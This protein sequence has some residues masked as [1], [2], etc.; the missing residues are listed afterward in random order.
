MPENH[1]FKFADDTHLVVTCWHRAAVC[2]MWWESSMVTASRLSRSTTCF[3]PPSSPR[4]PTVS[5][6]G[7]VSAQR[8][9]MQNW[10][11]FWT[12]ASALVSVTI[13]YPSYQTFLVMLMT[14]NLKRFWK[15]AIMFCTHIYQKT[16]I[17]TIILSIAH[18][19]KPSYLK[20]VT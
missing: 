7:L 17:N 2:C 19:T 6:H 13:L 18:I 20:Q 5:L 14:H 12:V 9:T 3:V 11:H 10:T 4:S 16:S 15:I 8:Q 1:I